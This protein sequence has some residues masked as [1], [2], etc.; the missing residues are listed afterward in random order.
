MME[1]Q[2]RF[3]RYNLMKRIAVGGMSEV[4]LAHHHAEKPTRSNAVVLKRILP[5]LA[6]DAAF[7]AMFI[8]E[9]SLA[10]Q[11]QHPNIV[12]VSDFGE[13]NGQLYLVMEFIDGVDAWRLMRYGPQLGP[14]IAVYIISEVLK[15][16]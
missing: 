10:A 2:L 3:G 16:L 9:A 7:V 4:F 12:H 15:G 13:F 5:S 14:E 11:M 6:S 1:S 8:N